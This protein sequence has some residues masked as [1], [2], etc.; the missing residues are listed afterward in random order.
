MLTPVVQ[1]YL[2]SVQRACGSL[3]AAALV[4]GLSATTAGAAPAWAAQEL[5]STPVAAGLGTEIAGTEFVQE[6]TPAGQGGRIM[7][8]VSSGSLVRTD[9]SRPWELPEGVE[10]T[11]LDADY[12]A[13]VA[14][15]SDG[16]VTALSLEERWN[17]LPIP[18]L[19]AGLHYTAVSLISGMGQPSAALL[20]SDGS[21]VGTGLSTHSMPKFADPPA[22]MRYLAI[23]SGG[24]M[25][26]AV[27]SDG[28][29]VAEMHRSVTTPCPE[30]LIPPAG[31]KYEAVNVDN[32]SWMAVRSDGAVVSCLDGIDTTARV[33]TP[34]A[35]TRF[36]GIDVSP[37][38]GYATQSND[39]IVRFGNAPA[40][41]AVP[42]GRSV[43]GLSSGEV[44]LPDGT[45]K[46]TG[47]ALL[48]DGSLLAWG[49]G[50]QL[51]QLPPG[52][53]VYRALAGP[54]NSTWLL[55]DSEP[56]PAEISVAGVPERWYMN[57]SA[58]IDITVSSSS[59]VTP[60]G[61]A[62]IGYRNTEG[63]FQAQHFVPLD[64]AGHAEL[65]M[66]MS[67][68]GARLMEIRFDGPPFR[69]TEVQ[70]PFVVP[71]PSQTT[72]TVEGPDSWRTGT[73]Y[74]PFVVTIGT[75]DGTPAVPGYIQISSRDTDAPL[76]HSHN[77]D[78]SQSLDVS[79]LAPG[80][81][82]LEVRH[83]ANYKAASSEPLLYPVTVLPP[84]PT[85]TTATVL[86]KTVHYGNQVEVDARIETLDGSPVECGSLV[87]ELT[88]G[89][90]LGKLTQGC[91]RT[92]SLQLKGAAGTFDLAPG[93][94]QVIVRWEGTTPADAGSANA[95][96]TLVSQTD[97]LPVV[98][99][100]AWTTTVIADITE[101]VATGK[102]RV[103]VDM[104][105]PDAAL[106]GPSEIVLSING[107]DIA[108]Q[109]TDKLDGARFVID[110]ANLPYGTLVVGARYK[111]SDWHAPSLTTTEWEHTP[112]AFDAPKP[113][114]TGTAQVDS[115]L[116]V[117]VGSWSPSPT[118][119]TYAWFADGVPLTGAEASTVKVP[120][121][122]LGKRITVQVTGTRA[123]YQV[124]TV[125]SAPTVAVIR[126]SF[127]APQPAIKGTAQVGRT[128]TVTRGTW[129][130]APSSVEYVWK[131]NG[132]TISTQTSSTFVVPASAKGKRLTVTVVG[133]RTG[134]TKK[135]V[136]SPETS[137]VAAGTFTA[138]RPTISGT[139]RVGSTLTVSRGT[140]SPVPSSVTFVWKADGV[141]IATRT[142]SRFVVPER[143]RG[144]QLTVTV[145]GS[146]A[147][148]TTKSAASYRTTTI[149]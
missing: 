2:R 39:V 115:A 15:R 63:V 68:P 122:A 134:Y 99:R 33:T 98:I 72:V 9:G 84:S 132:V 53:S 69:S 74:V 62:S 12:S 42:Q 123:G 43:V 27:R 89:T 23:D 79:A 32:R 76:Y 45:W 90:D 61:I 50:R 73:D 19:P 140:W 25:T 136:T 41:V 57:T 4:L 92:S 34:A 18:E 11:G 95:G 127:T 109:A 40:P 107:A 141:T 8:W 113:V 148:Y 145:T 66:R 101:D 149:R 6:G 21:V 58:R 31:T 142:S 13:I 143:V 48:D 36:V 54:G 38:H 67:W 131:A 94:H 133:S 102:V 121:S 88:D 110:S 37:Q 14:L 97:P 47:G 24:M 126:G 78:D 138:P 5:A 112:K 52:Q 114:V 146:L 139:M 96:P 116:S 70:R 44:Y 135:S 1:R 119:L 105:G 51:P 80:R 28:N 30:G 7:P 60:R 65:E 71:E 85:R 17:A 117:T 77:S 75:V 91:S 49:A 83:I 56:L 129:S 103:D 55:M 125:N 137:T 111:G 144:K 128:L 106:G 130:P 26:L 120:A 3:T 147:G 22:G 82:V 118:V 10:H 86:N 46:K 104:N 16:Q 64:S 81:Y 87:A 59:G 108:R 35:G 93:P 20:R 100:R 29:L 124:T